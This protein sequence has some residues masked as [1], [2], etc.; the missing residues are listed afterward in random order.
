MGGT[1]RPGMDGNF[2]PTGP[3]GKPEGDTGA[4]GATGPRGLTGRAGP[5]GE[6]GQL[7]E[8]C[9]NGFPDLI[10]L[11]WDALLTFWLTVAT[12]YVVITH[13]QGMKE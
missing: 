9:P 4:K 3:Q 7:P 2:G 13:H 10:T 5:S 8:N 12:A 6:K 11:V 1:G